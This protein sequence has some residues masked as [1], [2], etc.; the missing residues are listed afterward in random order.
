[1]KNAERAKAINAARAVLE[2]DPGVSE[3]AR[4]SMAVAE[5]II[6]E[7][8]KLGY[9]VQTLADLR[10]QDKDWKTA[11]PLLLRWLPLSMTI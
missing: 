9:K 6:D 7:L 1:V 5:P 11:I 2:R 10:H 3:R 8:H 4:R